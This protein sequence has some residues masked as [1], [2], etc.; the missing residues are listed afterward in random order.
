MLI[1][2]H[3]PHPLSFCWNVTPTDNRDNR[4]ISISPITRAIGEEK[5][6]EVSTVSIL[7]SDVDGFFRSMM[8]GPNRYIAGKK[9]EIWS[10]Q[11]NLVY[12]G[13]VEKWGFPTA[14]FN[15]QMVD[16][17]NLGA[18]LPVNN[19]TTLDYPD[20][21]EE[22]K[23]LPVPLIYGDCYSHKCWK[24]GIDQYL[25]ADHH[26]DGVSK[27][28]D[29]DGNE[30]TSGWWFQNYSD[31]RAYIH[32]NPGEGTYDTIYIDC[33]GKV[34]TP[35]DG[36][37]DMISLSNCGYNSASFAAVKA[38][39]GER[40][41]LFSFAICTK[42]DLSEILEKF[43]SS[44]DCD[45]LVSAQGEI[46]LKIY[47]FR[48]MAVVQRFREPEILELETNEDPTKSLSK[49]KY[50]YTYMTTQEG[51]YFRFCPSF[52]VSTSWPERSGSLGLYCVSEPLTAYDVVQRYIIQRQNPRRIIK[53]SVPE[54]YELELGD[55]IELQSNELIDKD[56]IRKYQIRRI[57]L[58]YKDGLINIE[59]WDITTI[60]GGM[61]VLGDRE[62]L[63][64]NWE[65]ATG[66]ERDYGYLADSGTGYFN[67]VD[68]GK[69]L[70]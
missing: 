17:L 58:G 32:F 34:I 52:E 59:C 12:T 28:Y 63:T 25:I 37:I 6:Y 62:T 55:I 4:I 45:F 10:D 57:E 26:I 47:D 22:A 11:G 35:V 67:P 19:I 21:V 38:I 70:Y 56:S 44:F 69:T 23:G 24:T 14:E 33:T 42:K 18:E 5:S 68:Q 16:D 15:L 30:I 2:C 43:C 60:A 64:A 51:G 39:H 53:L 61:F 66:T 46:I 36:L 3:F 20:V 27:V 9:I 29:N 41:Y 54:G 31:G 48:T 1:L 49:C 65:Q 40:N 7:F 8:S 50:M 13:V